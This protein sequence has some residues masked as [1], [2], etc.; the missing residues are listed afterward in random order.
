[1]KTLVRG[2]FFRFRGPKTAIQGGLA[3]HNARFPAETALPLPL[4]HLSAVR[5]A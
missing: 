3:S 4:N 1:M 5:L 2:L